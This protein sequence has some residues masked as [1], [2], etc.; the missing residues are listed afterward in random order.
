MSSIKTYKRHATAQDN[1]KSRLRVFT[2]PPF[3]LLKVGQ[4]W[5][6]RR[7]CKKGT[8]PNYLTKNIALHRV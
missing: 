4:K 8:H 2:S 7:F 5:W 1:I 6:R 3:S